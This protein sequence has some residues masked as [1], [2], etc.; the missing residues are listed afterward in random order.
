MSEFVKLNSLMIKVK[1]KDKVKGHCLSFYLTRF[2][3]VI[4]SDVDVIEND[5]I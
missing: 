2:G 5:V 1:D 4:G 3:C